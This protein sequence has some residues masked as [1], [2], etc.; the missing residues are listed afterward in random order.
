V[1]LCQGLHCDILFSLASHHSTYFTYSNLCLR[2]ASWVSMI[3]TQ[4]VIHVSWHRV[5]YIWGCFK[6]N[7]SQC[8][9]LLVHVSVSHIYSS[10]FHHMEEFI[11]HFGYDTHHWF[12]LSSNNLQ[13]YTSFSQLVTALTSFISVA[14]TLLKT[15]P[16]WFQVISAWTCTS[17]GIIPQILRRLDFS[18]FTAKLQ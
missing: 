13:L 15:L 14:T 5:Q 16:I 1:A 7:V 3:W 17:G 9:K 8:Q 2:Q 12:S 10:A 18:I 6:R 11:V 4:V